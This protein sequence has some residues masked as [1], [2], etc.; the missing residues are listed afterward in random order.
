MDILKWG[1]KPE[2]GKKWVKTVRRKKP[3]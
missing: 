2:T 1:G 3:F